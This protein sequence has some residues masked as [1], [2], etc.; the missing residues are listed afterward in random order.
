MTHALL[1]THAQY[2]PCK[3]EK[4]SC[5]FYEPWKCVPQTW[6]LG[7]Y[8]Y[9]LTFSTPAEFLL[10]IVFQVAACVYSTGL[11]ENLGKGKINKVCYAHGKPYA[12]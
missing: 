2:M 4:R 8:L 11:L 3:G 1:H 9:L 7:S 12:S 5:G 10:R 6:S